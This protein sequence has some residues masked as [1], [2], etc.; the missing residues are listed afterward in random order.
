MNTEFQELAEGLAAA[1]RALKP[2]GKLAVV[3]F[4]SLEDRIVK[5]FFQLASGHEANANRYAPARETTTARFEMITRRAVGPDE[6]E[7][8]ANPRARSAK[9]RVGRRTAA[10]PQ[11]IA[12]EALGVP[13]FRKKGR[14]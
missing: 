11:P 1:E 3:T 4:H 6:G 8:A 10:A 13:Q 9:L 12:P 5:R 7:L 2:G 14:R